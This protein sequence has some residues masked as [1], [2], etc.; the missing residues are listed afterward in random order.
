MSVGSATGSPA[1]KPKK[2]SPPPKARPT[3][4]TFVGLDIGSQL[5]KVVEVRGFKNN[6]N[7][8]AMGMVETPP[9]SV[10]GG[11]ITDPKLLGNTIKNLLAKSGVRSRRVVSSV[12]GADG[13]VVRV[14]EVA[15]MQPSE[16][17]AMMGYE[18]ERH[19]PFS[20]NDVH[21]DFQA[22]E[23]EA[24]EVSP[25]ATMEVLLAVA[26]NEMLHAHL[27]TLQSAGLT[28]VAI[29]VEPLAVG[30]ALI[31]LNKS[32][33]FVGKNVVIVNIGAAIT[34]VGIFK[35]GILRFPRTIPIAGDTFTRAIAD[36]LGLSIEQAEE[37][38]RQHA[39]ILLDLLRAP[40][41]ALDEN[42]GSPFDF[43]YGDTGDS[44]NAG[45]AP[46]TQTGVFDPYGN[47]PSNAGAPVST[48]PAPPST[49]LATD[50]PRARR[51]REVFD[52]LLPVLEEFA[53]EVR[54]SV[55]YFRSRYPSETV[56][57]IILCGGSAKIG[58]FDR[59]ME[60]DLGVPTVVGDPLA[61]A[62]VIARNRNSEMSPAFAVA[63]GLAARDAVV[64]L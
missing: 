9:G 16:L 56:D 1:P 33:N 39:T 4:G 25:D 60:S 6:L 21:M 12:A 38:K 13:V 28:P 36:H 15:A 46:D 48:T 59:Y 19:I 17:K 37:E 53:M 27:L 51:R 20:V 43:D 5:I 3:G 55:E 29:D 10:Q 31:D 26:K 57:Q 40:A 11:I 52:A 24:G 41:P 61:N 42:A 23:P 22:I 50:D 32:N 49:E 58:N 44:G 47:V 7:V 45:I 2:S 14:I 64:G 30:R 8:T 18:V 54:R 34:D 63:L 35:K 62:T